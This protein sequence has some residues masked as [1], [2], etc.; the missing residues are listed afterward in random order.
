MNDLFVDMGYISINKYGE[1]LC[2]DSVQTVRTNDDTTIMVIADGLGSGVKANILST[3]TSK[4]IST[5][6]AEGMTLEECVKTI[7]ETLPLCKERGL[8][9]STFTIIR[10]LNNNEAE[11]IQYDNPMVILLRDGKNFEYPLNSRI[12]DGKKI[13]ETKISL[14]VNDVFI[15][16]SDGALYA[17]VG[18]ALNLSW[19]REDIIKFIEANY[20]SPLSAK[21]MASILS[22]ECARLY[23]NK[24]SDDT[25]I[26]VVKI[27]KRQQVN[28]LIGP[29]AE[30][31]DESKMLSLFFAKDGKHIVCG[32]TTSSLV[33]NFLGKK[34]IPSKEEDIIG[35]PPISYIEGVDLVT[36][37]VLTISK[38]LEYAEEYLDFNNNQD[39]W[40]YRKDGASQIARL[41]FEEAT[42][43]TFYV[44]RAV[45][46]AH[47][48]PNLPFSFSIKMRIV[49]ELVKCLKAMGKNIKVSYF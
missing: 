11:I 32:G 26:S 37:G 36:E 41:L 29:P 3:L 33:A 27:R 10:T 34:V 5:M 21:V 1:Q 31:K 17:G 16:V 49:D 20:D 19:Q 14:K 47:E 9:Y 4:I 18:E 42:D 2:G 7:A 22:Q 48:N 40:S 24:H 39:E 43:I 23:D 28:L 45:N 38:V 12:I 8:A 25:T 44:G 30:T 35:V 13:Y 15:A 46:P 6:M